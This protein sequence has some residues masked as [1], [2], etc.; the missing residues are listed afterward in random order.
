MQILLEYTFCKQVCI[1][2]SDM[3][4]LVRYHGYK[5]ADF[6]FLKNPELLR[7]PPGPEGVILPGCECFLGLSCPHS[8]RG[9]GCPHA[10]GSI[11]LEQKFCAYGLQES[12]ACSGM[13][14]DK[15]GLLKSCT[16]ALWKAVIGVIIVGLVAHEEC[17]LKQFTLTGLLEFLWYCTSLPHR[18]VLKI[19][20]ICG[21]TIFLS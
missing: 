14:I 8:I 18:L 13:P 21:N 19:K 11:G 7:T 3:S 2:S 16:E 1:F 10:P 17:L 5:L 12:T 6:C 4:C 20:E 9:E 15:P